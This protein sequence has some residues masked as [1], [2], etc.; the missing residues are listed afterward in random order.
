LDGT[1]RWDGEFIAFLDGL[2]QAAIFTDIPKE[3]VLRMPVRFRKLDIINP[4]PTLA[5]GEAGNGVQSSKSCIPYSPLLEP[6]HLGLFLHCTIGS[7]LLESPQVSRQPILPADT[8]L[9]CI[10]HVASVHPYVTGCGFLKTYT[11]WRPAIYNTT[12]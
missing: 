6:S 1:C 5:I 9:A 3:Y 2:V 4:A 7:S 11:S 8:S 10:L 12:C